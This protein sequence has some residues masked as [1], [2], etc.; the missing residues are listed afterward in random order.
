MAE[1]FV[2]PLVPQPMICRSFQL[3]TTPVA[4]NVL[5]SDAFGVGTWQPT[6]MSGANIV[7][8]NPDP[9]ILIQ[10]STGSGNGATLTLQSNLANPTVQLE[11]NVS[12]DA[13][14]VNNRPTGSIFIQSGA[15]GHINLIAAAVE[16]NSVP[17]V[18]SSGNM[19]TQPTSITTGVASNGSTVIITTFATTLAAGTSAKFNFINSEI[20]AGSVIICAVQQYNGT[21]G[22]P[23]VF[24]DSPI[25]GSTMLQLNNVHPTDALN[26]SVVIAVMVC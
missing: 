13:Y 1:L 19:V 20:I 14:L 18:T 12:G 4:G 6:D 21:T 16:A 9:H 24:S 8:S 7:V 2:N 10:N 3:T 15:T 17:L 22:W 25:V 26:G 23:Y 11:Q 5:T